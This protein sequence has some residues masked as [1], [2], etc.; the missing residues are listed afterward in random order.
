MKPEDIR[1]ETFC[2]RMGEGGFAPLMDN[3]VRITHL[4]TGTV[5][6]CSTERSQ[7]AN[8]HAAM[9]TLKAKLSSAETIK[10]QKCCARVYGGGYR[11]HMCGNTAKVEVDGKFYCGVHDPI[12]LKAISDK[13]DAERKAALDARNK[14]SFEV[15]K[16]NR[17]NA[18]RAEAFP[19]LISALKSAEDLI[20]NRWGYPADASSRSSI[21]EEIRSAI[22]IDNTEG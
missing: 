7:H 19:T 12:R 10:K 8:R 14:R 20:S 4:P 18:R 5:S 16:R 1:I 22:A 9:E 21:L 3:G 15:E 6:E 11:G 17:E 13:K 2:T